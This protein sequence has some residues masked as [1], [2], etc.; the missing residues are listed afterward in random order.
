MKGKLPQDEA[1]ELHED[2]EWKVTQVLEDTTYNNP[3]AIVEIV[4]RAHGYTD[5]SFLTANEIKAIVRVMKLRMD[6]RQY[7]RHGCCPPVLALSYVATMSGNDTEYRSARILQAYH[8]G[9]QLVIQYSERF[10]LSN[11]QRA[12]VSLEKF[13]RY[14]FCEPV[15]TAALTDKK[16]EELWKVLQSWSAIKKRYHMD[17]KKDSEYEK[18]DKN[19]NDGVDSETKHRSFRHWF[20]KLLIFV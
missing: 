9:R 14:Y 18:G 15:K 1:V 17:P 4:I 16:D 5:G 7:R 20:N 2:D 12:A 13:L 19:E 10:D 6:M 3:H 8:D 11:A